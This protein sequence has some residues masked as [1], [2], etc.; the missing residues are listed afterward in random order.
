MCLAILP[1]H[2][3]MCEDGEG[4]GQK[5]PEEEPGMGGTGPGKLTGALDS[6]RGTPGASSGPSPAFLRLQT[7]HLPPYHPLQCPGLELWMASDALDQGG[8]TSQWAGRLGREW[9]RRA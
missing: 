9:G 4:R 3:P 1:V 6:Q 2:L 8:E 5:S 7:S